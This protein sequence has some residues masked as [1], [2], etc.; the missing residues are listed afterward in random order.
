MKKKK[1]NRYFFVKKST[2][3]LS[4]FF[5]LVLHLH[6][7]LYTMSLRLLTSRVLT[8]SYMPV[9]RKSATWAVYRG[10]ASKYYIFDRET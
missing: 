1:K 3:F 7:N 8:R 5:F 10:Y 9:A 4:S 6:S 2:F